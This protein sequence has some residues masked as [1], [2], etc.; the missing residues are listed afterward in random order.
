M[1]LPTCAGPPGPNGTAPARRATSRRPPSGRARPPSAP[2]PTP[3][4]TTPPRSA[5]CPAEAPPS[6]RRRT[7]R[8]SPRP[9][10]GP[11]RGR[12]PAATSPRHPSRRRSRCSF[13]LVEWGRNASLVADPVRQTQGHLNQHHGGGNQHRHPVPQHFFCP[14]SPRAG[15]GEV[16]PRVLQRYHCSKHEVLVASSIRP[17]F[18]VAWALLTDSNLLDPR[19]TEVRLPR[20]IPL[21]HKI[22]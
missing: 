8:R 2:P 16:P 21:R 1:P 5:P 11:A 14:P 17:I 18:G 22:S 19:K 15:E 20:T 7:R 9:D 10:R 4:A 3:G 6:A 12:W 13:S